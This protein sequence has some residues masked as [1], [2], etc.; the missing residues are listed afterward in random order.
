MSSVIILQNLDCKVII[1]LTGG[2][3]DAR[4]GNVFFVG[5]VT[6]RNIFLGSADREISKE[7]SHPG[8]N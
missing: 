3:N 8:E 6:V 7:F 2:R 4:Y 1:I 5:H